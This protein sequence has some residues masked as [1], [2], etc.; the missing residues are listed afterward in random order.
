MNRTR[1]SA[2]AFG[3]VLLA[4]A[5]CSSAPGIAEFDQP[6]EAGDSIAELQWDADDIQFDEESARAVWSGGGADVFVA[7]GSSEGLDLYCLIVVEGAQPAAACTQTLPLKMSTGEGTGLY[8][9]PSPPPR[10]E[11]WTQESASF[12]RST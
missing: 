7:R 10:S 6:Q 5:G 8:L 4:L 2:A 1:V 3:L 12:W 9:S 11:D